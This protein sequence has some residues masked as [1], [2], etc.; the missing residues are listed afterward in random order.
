MLE[1]HIHEEACRGCRICVDLCPTRALEFDEAAALARVHC[2]EDCIACLTCA[3]ACPSGAIRH[4]GF[5]AVKNF[6]RDPA[7][8]GRMERFL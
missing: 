3:Y 2:V 7:F 1:I 8:S 5:H 6:Y 4:S